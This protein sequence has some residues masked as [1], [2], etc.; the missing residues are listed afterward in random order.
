MLR[1]G[2]MKVFNRAYL[3]S[4]MAAQRVTQAE[5]ARTVNVTE[6]AISYILNSNRD[7]LGSTVASIAEALNASAADFYIDADSPAAESDDAV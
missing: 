3:A 1:E 6:A 2:V 4:L 5:L 7:P